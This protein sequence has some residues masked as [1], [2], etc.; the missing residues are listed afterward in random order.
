MIGDWIKEIKENSDPEELGMIL[1]HNGIV[2][3]TS[4]DG[5]VIKSMR[6]SY[7]KEMLSE[8]VDSVKKRE[9][10]SD[11]RVWINEG[12]LKIGDDIMVL[13]VAGRFRT[14]VL[15]VLQEVLTKIKKEIVREEEIF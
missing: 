2:R 11:V 4:K 5:K 6:L 1:V 8:Y 13:L 3:G 12:E 14:D 7:N 9:G 15:P 10:I